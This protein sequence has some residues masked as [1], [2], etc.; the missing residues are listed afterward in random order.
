M[1]KLKGEQLYLRAIEP[2]DLDFLFEL[3]NDTSI[4]EIS[5]TTA[6][7]S[8][9]ILELYLQNAYKDI[10]EAK[11]LRLCICDFAN[12]V[13]GLID[14]FDFDPGNKKVGLGIIVSEK[15][16]RNKGIGA[17][18]L[19]LVC[20]YAFNILD[21]HQVYANVIVS[22][23][24]SIHLFEKLNF[25]VVGVKKDWIFA[26]GTYRDEILYQKINN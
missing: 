3:E 1:L 11:Q 18:A 13:I 14:L 16:N 2:N 22:N 20:D 7:Y 12:K 19:T 21:V 5:G 8:R 6:P 9:Q 10:Y 4:W 24:A 15:K 26:N 17:E 25:K 23:M